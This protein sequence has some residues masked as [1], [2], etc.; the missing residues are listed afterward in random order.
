ML[1]ELFFYRRK[2]TVGLSFAFGLQE[3]VEAE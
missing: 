2:R 1:L 3:K